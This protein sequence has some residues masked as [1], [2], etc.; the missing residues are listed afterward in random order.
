MA[1]ITGK[2]VICSMRNLVLFIF[3]CLGAPLFAQDDFRFEDDVYLDYIKSVKFNHEGLFTS[4]PL[5]DLN[6]TGRLVLSFDDLTAGDKDYTYEI[7][8][9]SYTHLTLPTICSV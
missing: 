5:I 7:I 3:I 9:V 2:E 4:L 8:P 1:I 6:S